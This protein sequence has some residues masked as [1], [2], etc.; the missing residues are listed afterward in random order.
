[1]NH[2]KILRKIIRTIRFCKLIELWLILDKMM[3]DKNGIEI[4]GPSKLFQRGN[5]L[6]I[7]TIIESLDGCNFNT[8]TVWENK[9]TPGNTYYYDEQKP[10]GQQYIC[11]ADNLIDVSSEKYDFVLA[12]HCLEH[13]ANP[14]KAVK[15]WLRV[16]KKDGVLLLV[17]PDKAKTFDHNRPVTLLTHLIN[18]FE[19]NV[20]EDDLSHLPEIEKHHD[21]AYDIEGLNK[22]T[23][24]KRALN[25]YE[26]RCLHHHVFD[27]TLAVSMLEYL[28]I[29]ILKLKFA[30]PANIIIL[31]QKRS[32]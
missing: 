29:K 22:K 2:R 28:N 9:L 6:P 16:I 8:E 12:S 25:N 3:R 13:I 24:I 1:M 19:K 17:L 32:G 15:E 26:N 20:A 4:G 5:I 10:K 31:G 14:L 18:D 23:L 27:R 21:F 30:A 7:Y 11:E